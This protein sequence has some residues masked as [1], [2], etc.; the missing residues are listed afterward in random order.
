[1]GPFYARNDEVWAKSVEKKNPDG[2]ISLTMSFPVC[3]VYPQAGNSGAE[4]TAELMNVG[5]AL[6][7]GA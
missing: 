6:K 3:K 5:H 4:I 1:M 7:E 2:T